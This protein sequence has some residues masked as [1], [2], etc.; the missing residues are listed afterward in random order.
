VSRPIPLIDAAA[1]ADPPPFARVG[2]VG[3]GL[4][5]GSVALAARRRWPSSLIVG[6][7]R[8]AVLEDAQRAHAID[9]GADDLGMVAEVDLVVLAM[10]VIANLDALPRLDTILGPDAIV[11]D[12]GS[13][14]RAI[15]EAAGA[16]REG[17]TFIGGHPLAG[18]ARGGIGAATADLFQNRPWV[19]T[20]SASTPPAAVDR[21]EAF[22][23]ALG[24]LPQRMTPQDHDRV[25]A[26]V[27]HLPQLAASALMRVIGEAVDEEGLSLSGRGLRDTTRLASSPADIW[28]DVCRTNRDHIGDALDRLLRE[29]GTL[30]Q[31]LDDP[32]AIQELFGAAA[33][34][35]ERLR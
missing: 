6:V 10:P 18:A 2:I 9:V 21:L 29:L 22:I 12:V 28:I 3:L 33:A 25:T 7:D 4:I 34:W 19:L 35:R 31:A 14:K 27:S 1:T 17:I 11:T 24:A 13:T 5:G 16:L 30:R 15:V 23:R 32:A 26:W 8:N 20:P